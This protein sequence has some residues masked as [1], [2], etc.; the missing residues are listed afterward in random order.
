MHIQTHVY[1]RAAA[2]LGLRLRSRGG[3]SAGSGSANAPPRKSVM[4]KSK[5]QANDN[6]NDDDCDTLTSQHVQNPMKKR[7]TVTFRPTATLSTIERIT[8]SE[9]KAMHRT[10]EESRM[11]QDRTIQNARDLR[12][13]CMLYSHEDA[14]TIRSIAQCL[15]IDTCTRGVEHYLSQ[16]VYEE[17]RLA[18]MR[19]VDTVLQTQ[20]HY[21]QRRADADSSLSLAG[22]RPSPSLVDDMTNDIALA[23]ARLSQSAAIDAMNRG[24]ED[25]AAT[26]T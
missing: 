4:A 5:R 17:R 11:D 2:R 21:Q 24:A 18:A 3:P 7:K 13:L 15:Q 20:A 22:V 26:R 14:G 6:D 16:E 25:E 9:S 8:P 1:R 23:S 19:V 10:S 12:N